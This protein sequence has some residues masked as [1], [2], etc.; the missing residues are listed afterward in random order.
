MPD[1]TSRNAGETES[2]R[3]FLLDDP[4][5]VYRVEKGYLD[6]FAVE[7]EDGEIIDRW[8]FVTRVPEGRLAY[9]MT[10]PR[11]LHTLLAVPS[12]NAALVEDDRDAVMS[13][14]DFDLDALVKIEEWVF[15]LAEFLATG[16]AP[17]RDAH[18]L[19]ADPD[20]PYEPGAVSTH[21]QEILW[22]SASSPTRLIGRRELEIG[23]AGDDIVPLS[24]RTWLE[25]DSETRITGVHTPAML[26]SGGLWP[27]LERFG[28]LVLGYAA[29]LSIDNMDVARRRH[30]DSW[31]AHQAAGAKMFQDLTRVLNPSEESHSPGLA[32]RSPQQ[33]AARMVAASV[34]VTL[35]E[36]A[37]V[38][39]GNPLETVPAMTRG[40]GIR[41]RRIEVPSGWWRRDGPSFFGLRDDKPVAVLAD[42]RGAYRAVDG[43]SGEGIEDFET[44]DRNGLMFYAPLP[45]NI[46]TGLEALRHTLRGRAGDILMLTAMAVL[47][48][49]AA[50][51][52]PIVTGELLANIVPRADASMWIAALGALFLSACGI[53]MFEIVRAIAILRIEG[54]AEERLQV[55]V[56][57]R[58]LS[59]PVGFFRDYTAGD[60]ADR[61]NGVSEIRRNLT[62]AT[63]TAIVGGVF[64]VFSYAL[65]FYYS[66]QLAL[67]AGAVVLVLAGLTWLLSHH[68]RIHYRA[69][70]RI[71]GE[72]DGFVFQ[73]IS[74][75]T[76]L[77]LANAENDALSRW[78]ERYAAQRRE[79]LAARLWASAQIAVNGM[80]IP[81][82]TLVLFAFIWYALIQN[83]DQPVFGLGDFL[84]STG[85]FGQFAGAVTGLTLAWNTV[86][87]IL[88]LFERVQPI[89]DAKPEDVGA[90]ALPH[91]LTGRIEFASV[92]FR[93]LPDVPKAVDDL[94]FVIEPGDH[95]A[96][97]GPSGSGK[98]TIY[99]LLLG[100]EH[101]DTGAIFLD[102]HDLSALDLP[103]VRARMGV[104]M[105]NGQLA[106]ST[107]F[108]N[109]A[110]SSTLTLDEAWEAV[111]AVGLEEDIRAMPMGMHTLLPEG[112]NDLSGG[113]RQRLQ[114]ARALAHKPRILLFDEATSALDNYTQAIVQASLKKLSVT[115][116]VIAHRL[117]TIQDV[118]R[119]FVLDKG[120][121]V[122]TGRYDELM[123]A[124]GAFAALARRQLI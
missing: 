25:F 98:S 71:R 110:G 27:A 105:Q 10:P 113:Q 118:D 22:V 96:F 38:K 20:V 56:W 114:I 47:G 39:D 95:V 124:D 57:N 122:E 32:A 17:P 4:T 60:L 26:V 93:Y 86:V 88:P 77:R 43:E 101:P 45:D 58:L 44:I 65:I 107:I 90:N 9:A 55:A 81:L 78:A 99:R 46:K 66:W 30:H 119:I 102:G 5:R 34:G 15:A 104:V 70:F 18:L 14:D 80:F 73:I 36:V 63:A 13:M 54:R 75:L 1:E 48:G 53:A 109:V 31:I 91:D 82:S 61:A 50:L 6:I 62:G 19:E 24:E 2:P 72:I 117:T 21:H 94:S 106:A 35:G 76:K 49:L 28:Q 29:L 108:K 100:F 116:V 92:G 85:A 40:A 69:A 84:S 79:I 67:C 37:D 12:L 121:I 112:S 16:L 111:R 7:V 59:L 120:H 33:A 23:G 64:S 83:Q 52:T 51:L 41:T 68:H 74:G 89:L 8:L 42:G 123:A 11:A 3:S 87:G 103:A 97:V 115:R